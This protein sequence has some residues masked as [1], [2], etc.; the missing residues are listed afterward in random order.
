MALK[1]LTAFPDNTKIVS[2]ELE[3]S[4]RI[5]AT[6][7]DAE[8][9]SYLRI[10]QEH[11]SIDGPHGKHLVLAFEPLREPVWMLGRRLGRSGVPLDLL[12]P[13]LRIILKGLAL[14]HSCGIIHT[15]KPEGP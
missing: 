12:K 3:V 2:K 8:G 13:Y 4:Q 14:V 15:G 7:S 11:F 1:I 6:H 5:T 10:V 9:C